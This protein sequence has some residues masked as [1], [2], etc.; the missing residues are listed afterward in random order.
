MASPWDRKRPATGSSFAPIDNVAAVPTVANAAAG[1]TDAYKHF[2][3]LNK[4]RAFVLT[5]DG[6]WGAVNDA[7]R[8][9]RC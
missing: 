9:T 2:L 4:P 8:S 5:S 7:A 1:V 6:R 3:L